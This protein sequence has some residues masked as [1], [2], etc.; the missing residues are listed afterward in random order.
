MDP[1]SDG[2]QTRAQDL[3]LILLTISPPS[4][5]PG[6]QGGHFQSHVRDPRPPLCSSRSGDHRSSCFFPGTFSDLQYL[7]GCVAL[8]C[9]LSQFP[10]T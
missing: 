3:T 9:P 5:A 6:H 4:R 1:E 8:N 10:T 2:Q 7:Q